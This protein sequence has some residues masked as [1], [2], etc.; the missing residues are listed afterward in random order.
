MITKEKETLVSY[1]EWKSNLITEIESEHNTVAKGDLFVQKILQIYYGL[2]EEDAI[3]ATECAGAGDK[4]VDAIYIYPST[5]EDLP[6]ALV[7]Q[8]K[9]GSAGL[10]LQIM[11]EI[12]KFLFA[13]KSAHNDLSSTDTVKKV[14]NIQKNGGTVRYLLATLEPLT[15]TQRTDIESLKKIVYTDF[16]NSLIIEAINLENV[17][18][19]LEFTKTSSLLEVDLPCQIIPVNEDTFIGVTSLADMYGMLLSYEKQANGTVDT[20]YD[21]NIR[22]YL[23]RRVGSINE[24]IYITLEKEPAH[25][26]A[27]NNGITI[28]CHSAQRTSTGLRINM[29]YIV[30]GCQTTRTLYDVMNT[31]FSGIDPQHDTNN[32]MALYR[33]ARMAIK[34]LVVKDTDDNNYANDITR[35]SN[36]QNVIKGKDFIAL[37]RIYKRLKNEMKSMGYFLETQAGEYEALPKSKQKKYPKPTH[38]INSFEATLC[39]AAGLLGKPH[40]AFGHSSY[41]APGGEEFEKTIDSLTCDDLLIPWMLAGHARILGYTNR[42]RKPGQQ[43]EEHRIQTRYFFLFLFFRLLKDVTI[44]LTKKQEISNGEMYSLLKIIKED[45]DRESLP[46]HP[47]AHLLT[48]SD[49]T[50]ATYMALAE[51]ERWYSDRSAFFKSKESIKEEHIIQAIIPAKLK[52]SPIAYQIQQILERSKEVK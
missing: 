51:Q 48:L 40:L 5:E 11:Q 47:F 21:L 8:G 39:Y 46:Q 34:V 16:G 31:K 29:P 27:Y 36:K 6:R 32:R 3:D 25:F 52:L 12:Q 43:T 10:N 49:E 7:L 18:S 37:E 20:I 50:V 19:S 9:Y 41:F 13:L 44:K 17:Y 4:G 23:K 1:E 24:G 35:F 42:T 22:K 45:Y 28:T 2:S 30:N 33:E 15:P 38:L 26:I 14:A